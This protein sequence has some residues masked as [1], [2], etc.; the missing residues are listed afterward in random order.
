MYARGPPIVHNYGNICHYSWGKLELFKKGPSS[1]G[2]ELC[3]LLLCVCVKGA[4]SDNFLS[5]TLIL[6][7]YRGLEVPFPLRY[8][9]KEC[10]CWASIQGSIDG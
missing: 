6:Q 9:R 2:T 3:M 10:L 4:F 8:I 7:I 1:I 5:L